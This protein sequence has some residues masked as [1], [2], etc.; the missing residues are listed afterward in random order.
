MPVVGA[1]PQLNLDLIQTLAIAGL[2]FLTGMVLKR[3]IPFLEGLNIP[4]AG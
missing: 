2:I 4:S 3:K 1:I